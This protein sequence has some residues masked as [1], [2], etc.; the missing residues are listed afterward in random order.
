MEKPR[1]VTW[2]YDQEAD[3]LYISF[4]KPQPALALDLG[5]G[6][7]ARYREQD[8]ELV[9]FTIIGVSR[10]VGGRRPRRG[11]APRPR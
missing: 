10:I 11:L 7:L 8:G 6:M 2:D 1:K 5:E 4:G 3:T 9:G